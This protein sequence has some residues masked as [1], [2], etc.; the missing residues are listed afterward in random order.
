MLP[1][2]AAVASLVRRIVPLLL[3]A[4]A[5]SSTAA[6]A[7]AA[8]LQDPSL[9]ALAAEQVESG[10]T[11]GLAVAVVRGR[12][13]L[14]LRG[15]GRA[16]VEW[17]V[18]M[19]ADAMFE[20]GSVA[21]QFAAVS[22]LL[23][24][25]AERLRLDDDVRIWLPELDTDGRRITLRHLLSH[26]AGIFRFTEEAAWERNLFTP[27][28]PRDSAAALI[29][30]TP[31][32][33]A[34]GEAQAYSNAGI[35]LI[36]LVVERAS[37]QRYEDFLAERIFAPLGMTRSMACD[38]QANVARRAQGYALQG[39]GV[40]RV[41]MV[42]YGWVFASGNVC[43]T[44][45]DLITWLQALHGG[46]LLSATS[47]A[48]L[49][50][51]ASLADGTALQYGL[52]IKVGTDQAGQRYIGHGGTAPG[53]RADVTW[54]PDA[55]LGVIVL[56]NTSAPNLSASTL[57]ATLAHRALAL[58]REDL[59]PFTGDP[60]PYV[61]RYRLVVGGNQPDLVIE[62]S[63][64]PEGLRFAPAGGRPQLLPW[65]G[66]RFYANNTMTFTF[67][68][69]GGGAGP[70]TELRRDDAGNHSVLQRE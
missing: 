22:I 30:L 50:R 66:G 55:Q 25:D 13:T 36:G 34:P 42:N 14:L 69:P 40:R 18:P 37:G 49:V 64:S 44:A 15:Y 2:F 62:V 24:V 31:F 33:F 26:T 9:D 47:Y 53:F 52:G 29:R 27:G 41:P 11:I 54:Y 35:Y 4:V 68:R 67:G 38:W 5:A 10:R 16:N 8:S 32:R 61:G 17:D 60:T 57:A 3:A 39:G 51:P 7:A 58:P 46:R 63:A 28:F 19:P 65:V 6:T 45:G 48:E 23:L 20:V 56:M 43:S 59:R 70:M 12:D 21:K 1:S